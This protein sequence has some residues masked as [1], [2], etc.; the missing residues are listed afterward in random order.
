MIVVASSV[1]SSSCSLFCLHIHKSR[2]RQS[3][4]H[5][6]QEGLPFLKPRCHF[7]S[8][9]ILLRT[10]LV[11][12]ICPLSSSSS[13]VLPVC[14]AAMDTWGV[15]AQRQSAHAQAAGLGLAVFSPRCTSGQ[16]YGVGSAGWCC[17][18]PRRLNPPASVS[19]ALR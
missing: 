8:P 1:P 9:P 2:H 3:C 15:L 19:Q 13:M 18:P 14:V 17:P 4:C 10:F 11:A 5:A 6:A 7:T 12:R 16:S